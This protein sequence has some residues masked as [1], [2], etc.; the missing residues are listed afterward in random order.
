MDVP[1]ERL[2]EQAR[3]EAEALGARKAA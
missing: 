1:R 2:V 3:I